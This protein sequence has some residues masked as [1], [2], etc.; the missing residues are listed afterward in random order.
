MDQ[1]GWFSELGEVKK[2]NLLE[3]RVELKPYEYPEL[4]KF[5]DAIRHSYWLHTEFTLTGDIQ[6][7]FTKT[8]EVERTILKRT[9][10]AISQ[11]EVS[12]KTFWARIY[13]RL[14]KPEVAEVGMTFAE[15]EVRHANAY[16]FLL[17]TLR[18]DR[19]F[20]SLKE[21]RAINSRIEY[22]TEAQRGMA[23]LDPR[24]FALTLLLFS[25]FVEHISLFSQFLII[26][27]FNRYKGIFKA[28]SNIVEA[29]S[30]EEQIHGMF[31][32]ELVRILREENPGW[33]DGSFEERVFEAVDKAFK[34]ELEIVQWIYERGEVEFLPMTHTIEFLKARFNASLEGL[35]YQKLFDLD[36]IILKKLQWFDEELVAKKENDFFNKRSVDYSK[37]MQQFTEESIF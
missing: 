37:K 4:L 19:D 11:I 2:R 1:R 3:K 15:S 33:F 5:R 32:Q 35:G 25:S 10:L 23:Q 13:D 16:S 21:I 20:R 29:T 9:M 17:D 26:M 7:W 22:L 14:P 27:S 36:T 28:I 12:V 24:E 18:L 6:D 8:S 30:K 31:G 34:S